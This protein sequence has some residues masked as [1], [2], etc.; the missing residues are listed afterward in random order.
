MDN[1]NNLGNH[2]KKKDSCTALKVLDAILKDS[3]QKKITYAQVMIIMDALTG[4]DD[5]ALIARFP[6]LLAICARKGI[7]LDS[8]TLFSRYWESSPKR[9]NLEKLLLVSARLFKLEKMEAPKNLEKITDSIKS[10]Y[11]KLF[12]SQAIQLGNGQ[13][14][15]IKDIHDTFKSY[16]KDYL[17]LKEEPAQIRAS[18]SARLYS[19]LDRLFS[20][21][22][23]DLV[24]KKL[25][26]ESFTKT[27]REYYSRVVRKKLEAI[28]NG[29]VRD[30]AEALAGK[31]PRNR[32]NSNL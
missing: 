9:Q 15:S 5:P 12:S 23:K 32:V 10:K 11:R 6:L 30:I 27:E 13:H 24:L 18:H 21:K 7:E 8:Q 26:G 25:N 3:E 4:S 14:I 20:P 31:H 22:Q 17:A 19:Y 2:E 29:E 1:Q 16:T 28:A